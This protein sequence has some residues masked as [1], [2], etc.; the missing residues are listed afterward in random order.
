MDTPI[1]FLS[2]EEF[3]EQ[4]QLSL[5]TV[6]RNLQRG[7]I[8]Y[9]QPGGKRC[10]ILIPASVLTNWNSKSMS[11]SAENETIKPTGAVEHSTCPDSIPQE[12]LPGPKPRWARGRG[13]F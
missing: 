11:A 1:A 4:T 6:H 7:N 2:L 12:R 8:P 5:S 10:R 13:R 3:C 9:I